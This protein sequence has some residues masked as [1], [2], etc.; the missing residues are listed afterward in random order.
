MVF[1][2]DILYSRGM[3]SDFTNT[4]PLLLNFKALIGEKLILEPLSSEHLPDLIELIDTD[5]WQWYTHGIK[6]ADDMKV[7]IQKALSDAQSECFVVKIKVSGEV[8]GSSRFMNIDT[9]N[10]RMEIGSTW[11]VK[12]WQRTFVNT[13]CK[14][15]MLEWAF[16]N[17]DCI[18]VRF[19]T[20]SLNLSSQKAIERIGAK[21]NGKL[22]NDRI[23]ENGRIR[24]SM[25]Y[26]ISQ[27]DWPD[28][29]T[30]LNVLLAKY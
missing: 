22:M 23:C 1:N 3:E 20:D 28:V 29:K 24:H 18:S 12:R 17:L 2:T 26:S 11:F 10:R 8:V 16:E 13:E 15:L 19:Q 9:I 7:Y 25:V 4:A 21:F 5:I 27:K 30:H 14:K 6:T